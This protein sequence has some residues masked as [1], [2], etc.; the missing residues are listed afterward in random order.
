MNQKLS[1]DFRLGPL[2]VPVI[3]HKAVAE[4]A[5]LVLENVKWRNQSAVKRE[6]IHKNTL[7]FIIICS[8][9]STKLAIVSLTFAFCGRFLSFFCWRG[10]LR[11]SFDY[12]I[13]GV[14]CGRQVPYDCVH[15]DWGLGV[16]PGIVT[17]RYI[18]RKI[19]SNF[20]MDICYSKVR[21]YIQF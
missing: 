17:K 16:L 15:I 11:N 18:F 7:K 14:S 4:S 6:L 3:T 13:R 8:D 2:L 20:I 21:V 5:W 9:L 10:Y 1:E 12:H 19:W